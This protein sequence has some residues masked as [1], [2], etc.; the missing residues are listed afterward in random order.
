MWVQSLQGPCLGCISADEEQSSQ[1]SP[2]WA[3][4]KNPLVSK[5]GLASQENAMGKEQVEIF[6]GHKSIGGSWHCKTQI[7]S[8]RR[9]VPPAFPVTSLHKEPHK[10]RILLRELSSGSPCHCF[11]LPR[12]SF[13][14]G[15]TPAQPVLYREGQQRF[16]LCISVLSSQCFLLLLQLPFSPSTGNS[17]FNQQGSLLAEQ[18]N[19]SH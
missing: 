7:L 11:W 3:A 17:C 8:Q 1:T 9:R 16:A 15:D 18:E 19:Q 2:R 12:P 14:M 13:S 5:V 6:E 10:V 4:G